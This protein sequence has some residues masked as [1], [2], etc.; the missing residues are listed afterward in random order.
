[1]RYCPSLGKFRNSAKRQAD[2][3]RKITQRLIKKKK[4]ETRDCMEQI[5]NIKKYCTTIKNSIFRFK[6]ICS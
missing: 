3:A 1:M 6:E 4:Q 5:Y 2:G